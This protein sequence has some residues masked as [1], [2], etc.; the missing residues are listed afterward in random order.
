[1]Q[2]AWMDERDAKVFEVCNDMSTARWQRGCLQ[3]TVERGFVLFIRRG[4]LAE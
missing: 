4:A 3:S 2:L 1:M